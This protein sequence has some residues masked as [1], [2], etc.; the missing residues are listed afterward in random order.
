MRKEEDVN[1]SFGC[2][3]IR[4][5][6]PYKDF[7]S[8]ADYQVSIPFIKTDIYYRI[9]VMNQKQLI[10]FSHQI[11]LSKG[12]R[13]LILEQQKLVKR[14]KNY[15]QRLDTAIKSVNLTLCTIELKNM[16]SLLMIKSASDT[17]K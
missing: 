13:R 8:V 9:M 11:I 17:S 7:K 4:K 3:T 16:L 6:I 14:S 5:D 1:R 12:S 15:S 2:P 10:F